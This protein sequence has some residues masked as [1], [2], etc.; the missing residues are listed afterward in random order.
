MRALVAD[1]DLDDLASR[2]DVPREQIE[3]VARDFAGAAGA[4]VV[5]RTG[6]SL[7][8]AGTVAEWL[9]HVLNVITG[10]M[11]RPGGRRYEPGYVDA[12]RMAGM[13]KTK[14]HKSRVVG[15]EMVAGAHALS[16]LPA[17]ITTPG[18]GQIRAMVINCGNPVVSGP[19][20][21]KLDEALGQLDL[22][23]AIDFVQR[24]S[25]RHAHW[26]LP[27][28]HWLERDDLLAF[29]SNMH[30]EPYLQYGAK[31]V[32][33]PPGARQEWRIFTDLAIA[34]DKPLFRAKGLN[35]FIKRDAPGRPPHPQ[36]A[37]GVRAALDRPAGGRD[38]TKVQRPQDQM[39]RCH[40]A[41]ARMGAGTAGVRP[42]PGRVEDRRQEGAR[43]AAGVRRARA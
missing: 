33:P 2:C 34:M 30:D 14:P 41:P 27:A 5:T 35:G 43:G 18:P 29:T 24:E 36:A 8:L 13:V 7:H 16:E 23:V 19:D 40:G 39:A 15:R 26:L 20:G 10:R 42:L 11:D 28:V 3:H 12:I 17:E 31:A 32:E 9:G 25:H 22:L 37:P 4:M 6:V 1:A 38:R 21:A